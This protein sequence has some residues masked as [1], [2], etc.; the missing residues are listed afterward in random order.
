MGGGSEAERERTKGLDHIWY[1]VEGGVCRRGVNEAVV[2][3][4]AIAVGYARNGVDFDCGGHF[5]GQ[6]RRMCRCSGIPCRRLA[7]ALLALGVYP[8]VADAQFSQ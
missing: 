5:R 8:D 3:S 6:A 7:L 4:V 1:R 2:L